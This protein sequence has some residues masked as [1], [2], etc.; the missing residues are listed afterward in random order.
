MRKALTAVLVIAAV[1]ASGCATRRATVDETLIAPN[2]P[3]IIPPTFSLAPPIAGTQGLSAGEA[4]QQAIDTLFG[5]PAS[6][7]P[8]ETS[9]L[10]RAGR[11]EVPVGI[12]STAA[13]PFTR[14]VDKG[15]IT[16][17]ILAA[18]AINTAV[19]SASPGR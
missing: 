9:L 15:Q 10:D 18:P 11:S 12:R 8:A 13:D 16:R 2:A 14:I 6:R 4:Q 3:L 19:A 17:T 5:G 7:S 1:S